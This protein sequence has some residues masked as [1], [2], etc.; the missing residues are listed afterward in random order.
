MKNSHNTLDR[1]SF[2]KSSTLA[3][4]GM[5]LSFSWLASCKSDVE[6]LHKL[7]L[8]DHWYDFNSYLKIGNNGVVTIF[9]PNPE[10]GQNVMT[11]MPMIVA[12]ELDVA[13]E[14]VIVEQAPY[15]TDKFPGGA[16]G[17]FSGGSRGIM[18]K[19]KTLRT[20][21]AKAK[22]MLKEAAAQ[23]WTVP[24]EEIKTERGVL[25]HEASNRQATYGEM[26]TVA[27]TLP[28]PEN[29]NLKQVHEY[30]IIGHSKK[31][32]EGNNIVTG[33]T[34]FGIDYHT[35]GMLYA[36]PVFPS[37]FGMTFDSISNSEEIKA[38]PGIVDVFPISTYKEDYKRGYFDT[39]AFPEFIAIVGESTWQVMNAKK[40]VQAL[41]K[42]T[43]A[44]TATIDRFGNDITVHTPAGLEDTAN[45]NSQMET[46]LS[47]KL[48][49]VR[50]DGNPQKAFEDADRI[51]ERHYRA[52]YLA[53]NCMEPIN[54]FAHVTEDKVK[55]IGPLQAPGIIEPTISAR[56]GIPA[57]KI[58]IEMSRMGGGFGRRA[59]SS[60]MV[61]AALI[62]QQVNAPVKF[63]YSREDDM[64][65]G[66]YRPTYQAIYRAALDKDNN[67]L[68]LHIKAGGVPESPLFA[69]RFPAGC[70]DNYLAEEFSIDSNITTGAFRAPRSNFMAGAEQ[71]F[72]DE[73][74]NELGKDPIQFRL[75]LLKR[76]QENPVG[77]SN[78][79]DADRY[80]G[81]LKLVKEKS[82][83]NERNGNEESENEGSGHAGRGVSA[84]FCHNSYAA[85]VLD[86]RI[87]DD[88]PVIDKVTCAIDCG[89]VINPDA[90]I[91][92][93]EGGIID[94]IG[95]ALYGEMTFADGKPQKSNFHQYR[96]IRMSEAPKKIEVH[97][98]KNNIDPTGLGEPPFPPVFGAL[99][100]AMYKA[101]GKR[102]YE[103]PFLK[104]GNLLG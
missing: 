73:L 79:Y 57:E 60:Y 75:D 85:H 102:F 100:N 1:R 70:F 67:V 17:Q 82:G 23:Q 10:F 97:F 19:W 91:N 21:G 13:W 52:P 45:H 16:F 53:H 24:A 88:E 74:S 38:M 92:M 27:S 87:V 80:A 99:A 29:V 50:R 12:D 39:N 68:A 84:Y 47:G 61:E 71:S 95:N 44:K 83:W 34:Q 20:A 35:E 42:P 48:K 78:D 93:A 49:M 2:I 81:V 58:D 76:A 72:L 37:A 40:K 18:T 30:S 3:G 66:I 31:N 101:T 43:E 6:E 32:V 4:G 65:N 77:E 46:L 56:L 9:S 41:W 55:I 89:I 14:N 26:A 94:G 63:M 8:P 59:Y 28:V 51:I 90:A 33:Q 22:Q 25:S 64:E 104:D 15:N 36:M 54:T 7:E 62:S 69:N 96:M 86:L 103:Q 5:L 11:S 98:V